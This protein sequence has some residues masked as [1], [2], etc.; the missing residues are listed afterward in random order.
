MKTDFTLL[1]PNAIKLVAE[2]L[3]K[4]L[5]KY[6]DEKWRTLSV[7]DHLAAALR[8]INAYLRGEAF[9]EDSPSHLINAATRLLFATELEALSSDKSVE[10]DSIWDVLVTDPAK[11]EV[12]KKWADE[13]VAYY[14]GPL[15]WWYLDEYNDSS[16]D[17][18]ERVR[19]RYQ[20]L[21]DDYRPYDSGEA[22]K[23]GGTD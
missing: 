10:Y 2:L 3:T 8:H 17:P 14:S 22:I 7:K 11:A 1:P 4:G 18:P 15:R 21:Q 9:D 19:I 16:S 6:P 23:P 13:T 5:E 20:S 12:Y